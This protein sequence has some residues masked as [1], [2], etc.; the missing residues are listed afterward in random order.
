MRVLKVIAG[1]DLERQTR[2]LVCAKSPE[3]SGET[4]DIFSEQ[5][6]GKQRVT[7]FA[8]SKV[9]LQVLLLVFNILVNLSLAFIFCLR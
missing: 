7:S 1:T 5:V 6:T 4:K 3:A 2:L 8:C 9:H